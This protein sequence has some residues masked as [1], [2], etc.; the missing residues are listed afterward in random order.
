MGLLKKQPST[1]FLSILIIIQRKNT[2]I[3]QREEKT[4]CEEVSIRFRRSLRWYVVKIYILGIGRVRQRASAVDVCVYLGSARCDHVCAWWMMRSLL[5]GHRR[6]IRETLTPSRA[7]CS[8]ALL[9]SRS[10]YLLKYIYKH[11]DDLITHKNSLDYY[12]YTHSMQSPEISLR[13][14][15]FVIYI[16]MC[17]CS[18]HIYPSDALH[19]AS[20]IGIIYARIVY[21]DM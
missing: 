16:E 10:I 1:F 5:W 14:H 3:H 2:I 19:R 17:V 12:C 11:P 18:M 7:L 21:V 9:R 6:R 20:K 15:P 13:A 4:F 8:C